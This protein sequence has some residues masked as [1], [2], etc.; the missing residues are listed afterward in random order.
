[1][2]VCSS[3]GAEIVWGTMEKSGK[4][5]PLDALKPAEFGRPAP[6]THGDWVLV[7]GKIRRATAE[8]RRLLRP[9]YT[10]H[11]AHCPAA[12]QHRKR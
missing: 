11:F 7:V 8:D 10:S 2:A 3:C 12:E 5:M 6:V 1:M 9:T 4:P